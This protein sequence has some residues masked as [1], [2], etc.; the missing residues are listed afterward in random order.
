MSIS[1]LSLPSLPSAIPHMGNT[2]QPLTITLLNHNPQLFSLATA[3]PFLRLS[4]LGL[5]PAST[6][7]RWLSQ[8]R[9]YAQGS[10]SFIGAL[11]ARVHLPYAFTPNKDE[12]LRWRI[13][14]VLNGCLQNIFREL[15][16]FE[17]VAK[18]YSLSLEKAWEAKDEKSGLGF[19][20]SGGTRQYESLFR[21]FGTDP[22]MSLLEGLVVLWATEQCYLSAWRYAASQERKQSISQ[23]PCPHTNGNGWEGMVSRAMSTISSHQETEEEKQSKYRSDLDGGAL[24]KEFIP[25]W[26][27][28]EF[29]GFVQEIADLVNELAEREEAWRRL[30]VY[31]A[32]WEHICEVERR[33]WPEV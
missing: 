7:S 33:F 30:D 21:A 14:K 25:N 27:S 12:S 32:V 18:R 31:R 13:V 22:S 16:F 20:A 4:G 6:L 3:H 11:I 8:D 15:D 19:L 29:E 23:S 24:R 10:I 17:D 1:T 26:T 9:L 2:R 5:L 28:T